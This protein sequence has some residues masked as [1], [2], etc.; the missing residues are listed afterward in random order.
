M[1]S[2]W[3]FCETDAQISVTFRG[4]NFQEGRST[5]S[6]AGTVHA[7]GLRGS[8]LLT[9]TEAT[10]LCLTLTD[11]RTRHSMIVARAGINAVFAGSCRHP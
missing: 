11:F 3:H 9:L 10:L 4:I 6:A 7:G 5:G 1:E 2:G 8:V